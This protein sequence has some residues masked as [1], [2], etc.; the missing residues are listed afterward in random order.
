VKRPCAAVAL[1]VGDRGE[2]REGGKER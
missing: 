1:E 2:R